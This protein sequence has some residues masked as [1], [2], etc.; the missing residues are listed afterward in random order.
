ML[1]PLGG[2]AG[3]LFFPNLQRVGLSFFFVASP[4]GRACQLLF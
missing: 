1:G 2:G 3:A 4:L